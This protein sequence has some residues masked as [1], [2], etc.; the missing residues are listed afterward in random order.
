MLRWRDKD[1]VDKVL[2]VMPEQMVAHDLER[3][4]MLNRHG[5]EGWELIAVVNQNHR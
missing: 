5:A 1:V 3:S 2:G 4:E